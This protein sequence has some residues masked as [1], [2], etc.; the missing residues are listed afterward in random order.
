MGAMAV[1]V[2]DEVAHS[3]LRMCLVEH[4]EPIETLGANR[5]YESLRDA[6]GLRRAKQC[7]GTISIPVLQNTSTN[8]LVNF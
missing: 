3:M 1:I 5:P 6:V 2:I 7:G 4:Q 8:R